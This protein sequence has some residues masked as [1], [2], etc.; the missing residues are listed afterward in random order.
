MVV[1]SG[2]RRSLRPG[3]RAKDSIERWDELNRERRPRLDKSQEVVIR[4]EFCIDGAPIDLAS[5]RIRADTAR[6]FSPYPMRMPFYSGASSPI[7]L[8]ANGDAWF[9]RRAASSAAC[10]DIS[11]VRR[12]L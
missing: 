6:Y 5:A 11:D 4:P 8:R 7:Y 1:A 3:T 12:A 9:M 10:A 2:A